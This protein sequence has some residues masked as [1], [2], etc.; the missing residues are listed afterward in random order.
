MQD[1]FNA[2]RNVNH[3]LIGLGPLE[4]FK[5]Q[6]P[7]PLRR[8][9]RLHFWF[10]QDFVLGAAQAFRQ[11]SGHRS[12]RV[13]HGPAPREQDVVAFAKAQGRLHF[14]PAGYAG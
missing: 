4:T 13:P 11:S 6:A 3:S 2:S 5:H 14:P 1:Q 7:Q 9:K 8:N 12:D 10:T